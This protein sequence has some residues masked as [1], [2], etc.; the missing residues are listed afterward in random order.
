MNYGSQVILAEP[1]GTRQQ[2]NVALFDTRV[3]KI[4]GLGKRKLG[5]FLDGYN[6]FN[7]N[8]EANILYSSGASF[9]RPTNI[10]PPRIVRFGVKLDW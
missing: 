4:F 10:V 8:P 1:I 6:L 9:L 3:E 7:A 2:D 5:L